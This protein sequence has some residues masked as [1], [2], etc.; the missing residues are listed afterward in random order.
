M[1]T[2]KKID[3][4]VLVVLVS[5]GIGLRMY[6]INAP[7]TDWHSWRQADTASVARNY[8]K[9]G[10]D[11]LHPK[12]D[13][14]SNVQSGKY[15]INGYRFV[16]FPIYSAGIALFEK[17]LPITTTET[18][19]RLITIFSS[20]I[21]IILMYYLALKE[22]GRVAAIGAGAVFS[23]MPFFVYYSRVVLPDMTA[24]SL[25]FVAIYLMYLWKNT[26]SKTYNALFLGAAIVSSA[27]SILIKPTT[28]FFLLPIAYIFFQKWG[29][30]A[31]KKIIVYL[32]FVLTL[33]PFILWRI[34]ILQYPEGIPVSDWLITSVNTYQGVKNIFLRPA[35]FR[36]IFYERISNL[37]LGSYLIIPLII[38][39][40]KKQKSSFLFYSIGLAS[41]LYLFV[42]EGGNVQHDY[43]QIMIL[44]ALAL[45]IGLG[46][47]FI[48]NQKKL[49]SYYPFTLTAVIVI[50]CF[51]GFFSFYRVQDYYSYNYDLVN[52]AKIIDSK[53]QPNDAIVTDST[54]DT[55]LLYLADR[56]GYPA[57]T[58][59]LE[60]LKDKGAHYF[61]TLNNH[62]LKEHLEQYK[63]VFENNKVYIFDLT[64]RP[65]Q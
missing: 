52:I 35:F 3:F 31:L 10:F 57:L 38:G 36:W 63:L 11:F 37:I 44:P 34:W 17:Y 53:T 28:I 25:I 47:Q 18:Y 55:T 23:F 12:Y 4:I 51:S 21:L 7:L 6:K 54:G 49:F 59:T 45:F 2:F 40:L 46:I 62:D 1:N 56:R 43:Y 39:V 14:L 42:F 27:S 9:T 19:G 13:D 60:G 50:F 61:V 29:F 24:L 22:E 48:L 26:Q 8:V 20:L 16:E 64:K 41:L 32:F 65:N 33:I 5:I 58:D 15:N 30:G